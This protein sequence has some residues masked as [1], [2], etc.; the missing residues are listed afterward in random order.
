MAQGKILQ[1]R[2]SLC[3]TAS[4]CQGGEAKDWR[5][6]GDGVVLA[7]Q[8]GCHCFV[9]GEKCNFPRHWDGLRR[10]VVESTSLEVLKKHLGVV[11][12]DN[13]V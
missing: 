8:A 5:R 10:E 12:R 4:C 7:K 13:M 2:E 9:G 6:V 1:Q 3:I 11:L